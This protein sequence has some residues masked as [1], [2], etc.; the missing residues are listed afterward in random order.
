M[1]LTSKGDNSAIAAGV[2]KH[3]Q[4]DLAWHA[5]LQGLQIEGAQQAGECF[6]SVSI[7]DIKTVHGQPGKYQ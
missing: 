5:L 2:G 3:Q 4:I 1:Q 7:Y 6:G